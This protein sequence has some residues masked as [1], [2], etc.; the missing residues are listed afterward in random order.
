MI[1]YTV[2]GQ[3]PTIFKVTGVGLGWLGCLATLPPPKRLLFGNLS[4]FETALETPI[5]GMGW[6]MRVVGKKGPLRSEPGLCLWI[7]SNCH[8][9]S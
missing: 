5:T 6:G 3:A 4:P 8:T 9:K 2:S 1:I 7:Y